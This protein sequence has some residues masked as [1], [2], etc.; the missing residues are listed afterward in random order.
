VRSSF[1]RSRISGIAL[2]LLASTLFAGGD[3][4]EMLLDRFQTRY[5]AMRDLQARF[6]Q[7]SYIASLGREETSTG[8]LLYL[9][10]GRF[11]WE[12]ESPEPHVLVTDGEALR[13]FNPT[14]DVLQVAPLG[15][16]GL[17]N[18]ALG[19]LFG[20]ADLKET[21]EAELIEKASAAGAGEAEPGAAALVGLR[22]RPKKD[23]S[24]ERLEVWIEPE[25]LDVRELTIL[26]LL[27]N[28]TRLR[29]ENLAQN[30]GLKEDAFI[31]PVTDDT[32]VID[33]R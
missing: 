6:V 17:S 3:A 11:R 22:L 20:E 2:L 30:V 25:T 8:R 33:L 18:T 32:E 27:G 21:F 7:Q 19:F 1:V 29:L 9:R 4:L 15:A 14:E 31:I 28:R 24:F 10:P 13:M 12:V 16:G 5:E 23:P 26:D